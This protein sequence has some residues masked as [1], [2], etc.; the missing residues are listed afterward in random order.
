MIELALD[1]LEDPADRAN[2]H[3]LP[4]SLSLE[5]AQVNRLIANAAELLRQSP[6]YGERS[7]ALGARPAGHQDVAGPGASAP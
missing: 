2:F 1:L 3:D 5:E 7:R 4:T 6:E